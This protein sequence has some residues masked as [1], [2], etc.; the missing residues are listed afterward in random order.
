MKKI[1]LKFFRWAGS[2]WRLA[3]SISLI[4]GAAFVAGR[5]LQRFD[6]AIEEER[7]IRAKGGIVK[8]L[9]GIEPAKPVE[10]AGRG[11]PLEFR[12]SPL[13]SW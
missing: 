4:A 1:T 10:W 9:P 11:L 5:W 13:A 2:D 7:R 12:N 8:I 6:A 3:V